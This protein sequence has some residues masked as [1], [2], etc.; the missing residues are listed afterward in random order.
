MVEEMAMGRAVMPMPED[1]WESAGRKALVLLQ[2][3]IDDPTGDWV[4]R[5]DSPECGDCMPNGPARDR[6]G[7]HA[8]RRLVGLPPNTEAV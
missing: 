2:R 7:Y 6:C 3:A 4:T 5:G 1:T 8:L